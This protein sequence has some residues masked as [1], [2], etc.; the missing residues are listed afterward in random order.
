MTIREKGTSPAYFFGTNGHI[1]RIPSA[2]MGRKI[3]LFLDFDGTL[4]RIQKNPARCI[5]ADETRELLQSLAN[6]NRCHVTVLSGRSI[7]DI[8]ASVGIRTICYGGD[9]GLAISGKGMTYIHPG[10]LAAKP[11]IDKA[12]RMLNR[13]IADIEGAR[14]ER[15][16]FTVSLHYRSVNKEA[17]PHVKEV[18]FAVAAEFRNEGPLAVMKGKKVLELVPDVS[19]NKGSAALWILRK[20]K[21]ESLSVYIGDDVTDEFAFQALNTEG[22]TIHVGNAKRTSADYYLKGQCEITRLLRQVQQAGGDISC[23]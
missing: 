7:T 6:S 10:A 21:S 20:L 8:K 12:G 9:H 13:K 2:L 17:V 19:W 5:L 18:F 22:I 1:S 3:A 4:V 15:K 16:K 11:A 23:R 14:V